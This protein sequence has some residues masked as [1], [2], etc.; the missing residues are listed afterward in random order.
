VNIQISEKI[1]IQTPVP[2]EYPPL[3]VEMLRNISNLKNFDKLA[4]KMIGELIVSDMSQKLDPSQYG[5][6]AGVSVQHYLMKMLHQILLK[7]D[8][9]QQ[10]DTFAVLAA[11]IDWKQAFPRQDPTLGVQSFIDNGV[12]GTLVPLLVNYFQNRVMSVKW[13]KTLSSPRNLSG[14]GPQ[15]ATLGLLEYLS[16]S[17]DNSDHIDPEN[18]FKWL[19]DLTTLEVINLLTIGI[20][21]F[22]IKA[23]VH[24]LPMISLSTMDL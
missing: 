3:K 23:Q 1:E 21:C 13:H 2:K 9:N 7:L 5:N 14:G 22:N 4:E 19:D 6:R 17:N 24:T 18:R 16:Q 11:M 20:S 12:R 8:N 10:G 15:G